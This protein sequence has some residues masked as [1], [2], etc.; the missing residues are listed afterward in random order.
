M[1]QVVCAFLRLLT[2]NHCLIGPPTS[3]SCRNMSISPSPCC[4]SIMNWV[5]I[6]QQMKSGLPLFFNY[7][8]TGGVE[9]LFFHVCF[10]PLESKLSFAK[11][12]MHH[13]SSA[14]INLVQNPK[15]HKAFHKTEDS[16]TQGFFLIPFI[17]SKRGPKDS[18][19]NG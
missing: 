19:T 2:F 1:G 12:L 17:S 5:P 15:P 3:S 8:I 13:N 9:H 11:L 14:L 16:E 4:Y 7:S 6:F 10:W 18:R